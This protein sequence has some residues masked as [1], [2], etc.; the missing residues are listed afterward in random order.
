MS[1][2]YKKCAIRLT[3]WETHRTKTDHDN[4]L[5]MKIFAFEFANNYGP[6]FYLAYLRNVGEFI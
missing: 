5:I 3:K 2:L 6:L 4:S 1:W